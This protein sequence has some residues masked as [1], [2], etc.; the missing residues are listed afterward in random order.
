MIG[1]RN[2][3]EGI[4]IWNA[5]RNERIEVFLRET[6]SEWGNAKVRCEQRWSVV[7]G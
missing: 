1:I 3:S 2:A 7:P 5:S 4:G 6:Q